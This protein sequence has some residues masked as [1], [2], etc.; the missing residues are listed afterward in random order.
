M[1]FSRSCTVWLL[2]ASLAGCSSLPSR[3]SAN[4]I[5][6]RIG[7]SERG[8]ASWYGPGFHGNRT[9]SGEVFNMYQFTAAHRTLPF[10]S[11]IRVRSLVS[12]RE[13]QVRVNDRG[14]FA[15]GRILDLSW[16]AGR[17][18]GL[19]ADGTQPVEVVVVGMPSDGETDEPLRVQV[20]SFIEEAKA[21]ALAIQL[22]GRYQNV[23]MVVVDLPQGRRYRV[24]VG[25]FD[26]EPMA[27]AVAGDI[28]RRYHLECVVIRDGS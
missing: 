24:Q 11:L 18:I 12:G 25:R 5:R 2:V 20:A 10:G 17:A 14:P 7:Y 19:T 28:D 27:Q 16:A 15:R 23:R 3:S 8:M 9:A 4:L 26:S 6:Y 22:K 21:R 13:V 1:R